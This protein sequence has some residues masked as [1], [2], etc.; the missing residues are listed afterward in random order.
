MYGYGFGYPIGNGGSAVGGSETFNFAF[1]FDGTDEYFTQ[2][3]P[4]LQFS[5]LNTFTIWGVAR[6]D[7]I[8]GHVN[9]LIANWTAAGAKGFM[10]NISHFGLGGNSEL[11]WS[12]NGSDQQYISFAAPQAQGEWIWWVAYFDSDT[13]TNS[14]VHANAVGLTGD[15]TNGSNGTIHAVNNLQIAN[16]G[17]FYGHQSVAAIAVWTG[18]KRTELNDFYTNNGIKYPAAIINAETPELLWMAKDNS[19]TGSGVFRY[20]ANGGSFTNME[21]GDKISVAF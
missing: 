19:P 7:D 15:Y 20:G 21:A 1:S 16:N 18:D 4:S 5:A 6:I 14:T 10:F 12:T 13:T 2:G 3:A 8:A 17:T 11:E 9:T